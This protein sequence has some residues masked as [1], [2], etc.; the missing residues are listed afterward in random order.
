MKRISLIILLIN[1]CLHASAQDQKIKNDSVSILVQQYFNAKNADSLYAL[2]GN[3]FRQNLSEDQFKTICNN[4]LFPLGAMQIQFES[5]S[6]NISRYKA[7][8]NSVNLVLLIGLNDQGKLQTLLFQPYVSALKKATKVFSNNPL[9]TLT[10]KAVDSIVQ[11]Y[12]SL[13]TTH[14]ISIGILKNNETHFYGYGETVEGN[15]QIPNEQSLF[16][17]GSITKT[18][19][20]ILL[21]DAVNSGKIK[22]DDPVNKYLP[23]S[24]PQLQYEG[25]PVTIKMLSNH[26]SGIP[27]MPDN[28][29]TVAT[30]SLNPYK[31]YDEHNLFSFYKSLKLKRM[32]GSKYEY[33]NLAV[34]TLGIILQHIY[35]KSFEQLL[36]EKICDP[37]QMN[38]TR[39]YIRKNDSSKVAVGYNE[40]GKYN[41]P[42]DFEAFAAAGCIRS[43][44]EDML[45]YAK[46]NL[47]EAPAFLN[48]DI[49]LTHT[50]TFKDSNATVALGWHYIKA[51]D[52]E[53][54]FHNGGTGGYRSYLGINLNKK[55]AAVIL[56]NTAVSV[57]DI[58]NTLIKFLDK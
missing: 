53:I 25:V 41:G 20:A 21:S 40:E 5:F 43:S 52:E 7:A 2:A 11:P 22:L 17:I 39:Q 26:S 37:L 46:A 19:T 36:I 45:K 44:A 12:A 8:F 38:N 56:S 18:F 50:V 9:Q 31:D 54:L 51:G 10:D 42:W 6:N 33:S 1:I 15:K 57:D 24:I 49:Q 27:R 35:S 34:A 29:D 30:D 47:G 4:N 28:F 48:K 55:T 14:A 13:A 32:P 58:G 3:T 16:E 23:D